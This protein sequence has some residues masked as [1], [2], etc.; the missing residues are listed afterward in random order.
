MRCAAETHARG[1]SR[2]CRR[3]PHGTVSRRR[4]PTGPRPPCAGPAGRRT[5]TP[6]SERAGRPRARFS[7]CSAR[8]TP[9]WSWPGSG[10]AGPGGPRPTVA[11]DEPVVSPESRVGFRRVSV[12]I[13]RHLQAGE[14]VG[15]YR[16]E[17]LV[18]LGGM[19]TVYAAR[20]VSLD[21]PV[22]LKVM[23]RSLASDT[24]FVQR[25]EREART[26][27]GLEHPHV[28]PVYDFGSADGHLYIAMQLVDGGTVGDRLRQGPLSG[29]EALELLRAVGSA[30][31]AAH[32]AGL[33]HRDIKPQ[34][35][36]LTRAGWAYLAD[37]GV[38]KGVADAGLT[39]TGAF[40]GTAAYASPEQIKAEDLTVASDVY[41]LACLACQLLTGQVPFPRPTEA[42]VLMAHL[43]DPPPRLPGLDGP[44]G[45]RIQEVLD[46]A[47][48]K[49]PVDRETDV[50]RFVADIRDALV[51]LGSERLGLAPMFPSAPLLESATPVAPD[52]DPAPAIVPEPVAAPERDVEPPPPVVAVPAPPRAAAAE[53]ETPPK[54]RRDPEP[55]AARQRPTLPAVDARIVGGLAAVLLFVAGFALARP[56]GPADTVPVRLGGGLSFGPVDAAAQVR[57]TDSGGTVRVAGTTL[58][59]TVLPSRGPLAGA[60]P[61]DGVPLR[62]PRPVR[63][64]AFV[65]MQ[66]GDRFVVPTTTGDVEL[67]CDGTVACLRLV[68]TLRVRGATSVPLGIPRARLEAVRVQVDRLRAAVGT[69]KGVLEASRRGA[70]QARAA[71]ELVGTLRSVSARLRPLAA[72]ERREGRS[73][74]LRSVVAST[75]RAAARAR[76]LARAAATADR[77]RHRKAGRALSSALRALRDRVAR[78]GRLG[79]PV[80][81]AGR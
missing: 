32:D 60:A 24:Q 69:A 41:S 71:R 46:R 58:R 80:K 63:L 78:A 17:R 68:A 62:A 75:D 57:R 30:L 77:G 64:G 56:A 28:V 34:N 53:R 45:R 48:A 42:A 7:V 31:A 11:P 12:G 49:D 23:D 40:V 81:E 16:I 6:S 44:E 74:A 38:V 19:S 66:D 39:A 52:P 72:Q 8:G 47:L 10:R 36:L 55:R 37:F 35:V 73:T 5:P 51:G 33:V 15:A 50:E 1:R 26:A 22:A 25:F 65:A 2:R 21:R 18:G 79:Y 13:G 70:T 54:P 14:V 59:A 9:R 3:G 61:V 29:R 67:R 43:A 76:A 4:R 20:Q 27:A